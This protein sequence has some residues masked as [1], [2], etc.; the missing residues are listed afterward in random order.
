MKRMIAMVLTLGAI[1]GSQSAGAHDLWLNSTDYYVSAGREGFGD[2]KLYV[3][4]GHAYPLDDFYR[5]EKI[6]SFTLTNPKGVAKEVSPIEGGFTAAVLDFEMPGAHVAALASKTG[7]YTMYME[8]GKMHHATESMKGKKPEDVIVSVY[9]ENY[10][11]SV[12]FVGDAKDEAY[13]KPVGHNLE[14]IPLTDPR[15]VKVGDMF[16]A[17]VM[18]E[19]K[20]A[21]LASVTGSHMGFDTGENAAFATGT[22][23]DGK[24]AV[25]ILHW[26][27]QIIKAKVSMPPR[28]E[29]AGNCRGESYAATLTF[30][31]K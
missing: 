26:G 20:P 11:K 18:F 2:S 27:P 13:K 4:F 17:Q 21:K 14:I 5:I 1:L 3:G 30:H 23:F 6:A 8:N 7:Y 16:E 15:D 19:G 31:V 12:L 22:G 10:A 29:H 24:V 9:F 25:R 28:G